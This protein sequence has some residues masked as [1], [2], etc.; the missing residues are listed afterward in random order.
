LGGPLVEMAQAVDGMKLI[1]QNNALAGNVTPGDAPGFP[2]TISQPGSYRLASNLTVPDENTTA[3]HITADNVTVDLNGFT[4]LGPTVCAGSPVVCV[5]TGTGRGVDA[6]RNHITVV[7]GTISGTGAVGVILG[8]NARAEQL[9]VVSTG[10]SGII[11]GAGS[12]VSV[13]TS[14][15]IVFFCVAAGDGTTVRGNTTSSNGVDGISAGAGST[16]SGNTAL[17]NDR[18]GFFVLAGSAVIRNTARSNASF[19]LVLGAETGYTHNVLSDNG[20]GAVAGGVSLGQNL[21]DGAVC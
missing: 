16:V 18:H 14:A 6:V 7:N 13:N 8:A 19:G 15:I 12:T 1:A 11:A 17:G 2:V 3:I 9:R 20:L 5:P 4:I 10:G 21:C